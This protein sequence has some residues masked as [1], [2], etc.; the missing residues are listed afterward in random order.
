MQCHERLIN[1]ITSYLRDKKT[2]LNLPICK[3]VTDNKKWENMRETTSASF[4]IG[5]VT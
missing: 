4:D 5:L 2:A 1:G 3:N